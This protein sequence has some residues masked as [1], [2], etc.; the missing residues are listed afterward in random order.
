VPPRA[1][2]DELLQRSSSERLAYFRSYTVA[3]PQLKT[4]SEALRRARTG[5]HPCGGVR[6]C[7]AGLG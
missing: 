5:S 3:H 6:G 2:P 1:F 7:R 4:V